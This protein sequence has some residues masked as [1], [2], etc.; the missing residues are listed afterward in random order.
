M[1]GIPERQEEDLAGSPLPQKRLKTDLEA[2]V[3]NLHG[4]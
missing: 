4:S 1:T 2:S 3:I